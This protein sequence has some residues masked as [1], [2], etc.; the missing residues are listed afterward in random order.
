[1]PTS[2]PGRLQAVGERG[3]RDRRGVRREHAVG[4]DDRLELAEQRPL[5]VERSRRSPRRPGRRR[6]RRRAAPRRRC[7]PAIA[8]ASAAS[9]LPLAA[10][11]SSVA[12]S[13]RA[14]RLRRRRRGCRTGA[15][16]GP[17]CAATW[18]M[19]APMMPAPTTKTVVSEGRSIAM[20]VACLRGR[21]RESERRSLARSATPPRMARRALLD[22][23]R[24][25]GASAGGG[26][27]GRRGRL[28][29]RRAARRRPS[30][31][32]RTRAA[33]ARRPG[34]SSRSRWLRAGS[35]TVVMPARSAASTFSLTPPI[36]STRPR[37]LISPVI[38]M[39]LRT[40]RPVQQRGERDEHRDARARPVLRRRARRHVDVDVATSR[41]ALGVDAELRRARLHERQRRL[42]A[43]LHH[44]AELAGEDQLAAAGHARRLDE[45]DVAADRRP[46][47]A[48][49]H[50]RHARAHRDLVL[51]LA[52]RRG[53]RAGPPASIVTLLRRC[54]RRSAPRRCGSTLPISRSRLRT[55]ASRV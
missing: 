24:V 46:G 55:P 26:A 39:S 28:E 33:R 32:R 49:R 22:P 35:M 48:G 52:R 13:L 47:E 6:R 50:A 14:R 11:P 34:M 5:G 44:V 29:R 45:Q 36:G 23:R 40:G 19:P 51:E 7:A 38:A 1:M 18:A 8:F 21:A 20:A 37:R 2:R 54:L 12:A 15:P 4:A 53:S 43:L 17:A 3:D 41:A 10:R 42:R 25:A 30:R 9:S 27:R 31:A 16:D